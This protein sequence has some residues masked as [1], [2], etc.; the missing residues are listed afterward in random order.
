LIGGELGF[1][2][3]L[4]LAEHARFGCDGR[5]ETIVRRLEP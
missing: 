3:R 2:H 4:S 1:N 5:G